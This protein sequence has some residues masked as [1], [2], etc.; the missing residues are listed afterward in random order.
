MPGMPIPFWDDASGIHLGDGRVLVINTDMLVWK[1]DVP[2]G[3]TPFQAGRKAVVM[4][5]SDLGAKGVQP[6]AFMPNLAVPSDIPVVNVVEMAKGFESGVREYNA[7]VVGGDTNEACDVIISGSALGFIEEKKIMR[8]SGGAK[9]GHILAVS[10]V[11]G[12]TS[13]GF[14][15]LLDGIELSPEVKSAALESIY[16]PRARVKEGIALA[17]TGVVT[18]CID[19]SDGLSVS[20]YDLRRSMGYGFI[21]NEL[22]IHPLVSK[23]VEL[24]GIDPVSVAMNGGEEYELV[25]TYPPDKE[26]RIKSALDAAGCKLIKIGV[27]SEREDIVYQQNEDIISIEKGGWD[28]F[29]E[30]S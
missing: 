28:H 30:H 29:R 11:F 19:S 2:A 3:M 21:V 18:S 26:S 9:P 22:P 16:M 25:F 27:V 15:H 10:G 17:N 24:R 5:V 8:R 7:Y 6:I 1:T 14:L 23:F 20:L 13:V 12:L 4:N